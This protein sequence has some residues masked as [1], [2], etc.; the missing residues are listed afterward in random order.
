MMRLAFIVTA[1]PQP[2]GTPVLKQITGL[3]DRGHEVDI[4]GDR[5]GELNTIHPDVLRYGLLDRTYYPAMP[6]G[7]AR[8]LVKGT[9]LFARHVSTQPAVF[10]RAADVF[11][12]GMLAWSQVL[13][14]AALPLLHAGRYDLIHGQFG[15]NGL[16]GLFFRECGLVSAPLLTTF[17]GYDL[18]SYPRRRGKNCYRRLFRYGE[19]FTAN[20]RF[21]A[22]K[23]LELGCPPEKLVELPTGINLARFSPRERRWKEGTELRLLTVGRLEEVKGVEYGIRAVARIAGRCPTL[24][25]QIAGGGPLRKE[26]EELAR[27]LGV[28]DRVEF[29]GPQTEDQVRALY[30]DAHIFMLP[31]VVGRDGAEEG[32]GGVCA[33][34]QATAL[35]VVASRV[36]GISQTVDEGRSGFLVEPGDVDALANRLDQLIAHPQRWAEMGRAGRRHVQTHFDLD[37]SIDRLVDIYRRLLF[38]PGGSVC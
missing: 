16:K 31:G 24:R 36:G 14:Y 15:P 30:A 28:A 26:L 8:R 23:A 19:F 1:F 4:F 29:L 38:S 13:T 25:Y 33:E 17:R 37:K 2:S 35:P 6:R 12:Y 5:P 21:L 3:I 10:L 22:A 27:L 9:W 32:F 11:R 7:I 20:S 18:T 34:A